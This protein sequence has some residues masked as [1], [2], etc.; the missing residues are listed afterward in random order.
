MAVM[1]TSRFSVSYPARIA[2]MAGVLVLG[3]SVLG[4]VPTAA[5]SQAAAAHPAGSSAGHHAG[6]L[7]AAGAVRE[8][9]ADLLRQDQGA[10]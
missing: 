4:A 7:G 5:A 2:A 8:A 9:A 3:G 1:V 10:A 6:R